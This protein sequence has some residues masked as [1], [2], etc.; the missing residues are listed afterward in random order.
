MAN[1]ILLFVCRPQERVA[2]ALA[3]KSPLEL[4][5]RVIDMTLHSNID[6]LRE[7]LTDA[8]SQNSGFRALYFCMGLCGGALKGVRAGRVP[9]GFIRAHDCITFALG[10]RERYLRLF[11]EAPGTYFFTPGWIEAIRTRE[12]DAEQFMLDPE[13]M[14]RLREKLVEAY[15]EDNG[16]FLFDIETSWIK[17]YKR[18]L[19]IGDPDKEYPE[20]IAYLADIC[21]RSGWQLEREAEN[22]RLLEALITGDINDDDFLV[23]QPG[24]EICETGDG[25]VIDGRPC[26]C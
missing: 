3:E 7:Y 13:G 20:D 1:K 5:I 17:N 21:R 26:R 10:P 15:G 22:Y 9:C 18:A 2:R 14:K 19:F 16:L 11:R 6:R 4:D 24:M 12:A 25:R 23:L 8:I